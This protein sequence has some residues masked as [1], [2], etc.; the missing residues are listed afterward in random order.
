[1]N[2]F[3]SLWPLHNLIANNSILSLFIG[4]VYISDIIFN[5]YILNK[6]IEICLYAVCCIIH[7]LGKT[8]AFKYTKG[9]IKNLKC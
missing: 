1:M 5:K 3:T 2:H 4:L 9:F 8:Y 7:V 6:T